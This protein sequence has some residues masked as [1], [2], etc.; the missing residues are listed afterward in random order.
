LTYFRPLCVEQTSHFRQGFLKWLPCEAIPH[1]AFGRA[2]LRAHCTAKNGYEFFY[3]QPSSSLLPPLL[4][5]ACLENWR[6]DHGFATLFRWKSRKWMVL[7]PK[8][9]PTPCPQ[10]STRLLRFLNTGA[11]IATR[12]GNFPGQVLNAPDGVR[13]WVQDRARNDHAF[14][15]AEGEHQAPILAALY[16]KGRSAFLF[17]HVRCIARFA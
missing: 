10:N 9:P 16:S 15:T 3:R 7:W 6:A 5:S 11:E 13:G 2:I 12:E 8:C 4:Q 1:P 17:A 14:L